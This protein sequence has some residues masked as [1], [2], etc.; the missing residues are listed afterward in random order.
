MS[1][2]AAI[3]IIVACPSTHISCVD[4]PVTVI[5]Y[6][7]AT[8]CRSALPAEMQKAKRFIDHV[9]GDCVPVSPTLLVGSGPIH[10]VLRDSEIA[11]LT[12]MEQPVAIKA[13]AL[14]PNRAS[15]PAP[16]PLERYVA[17]PGR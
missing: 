1:S 5:S 11:A 14:L 16:I 4:K 7:Q 10:Q 6:K 15:H 8:E 9:Y 17:A 3:M 13:T 12:G 2:F